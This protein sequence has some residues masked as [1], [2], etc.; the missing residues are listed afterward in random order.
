VYF[1][2]A[3][4]TAIAAGTS[5]LGTNVSI[6]AANWTVD[7]PAND[8]VPLGEIVAIDPDGAGG[9]VEVAGY[10]AVRAF[11]TDGAVAL[12]AS[13]QTKGA[14]AE[15]VDTAASWNGTLVIAGTGGA[16][17]AYVLVLRGLGEL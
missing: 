12:K 5:G 3:L 17:T 1:S 8:E 16:G 6:G 9:T 11:T 2:A 13:I 7:V 4:Q 15:V 14:G 10:S